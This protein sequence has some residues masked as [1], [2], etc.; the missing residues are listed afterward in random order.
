[1]VVTRDVSQP[2]TSLLKL[3]APSNVLYF[4]TINSIEI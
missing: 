1:M 4:K 3:D 2:E